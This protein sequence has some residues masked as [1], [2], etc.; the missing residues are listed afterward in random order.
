MILVQYHNVCTRTLFLWCNKHVLWPG[1][2]WSNLT[3]MFIS[4]WSMFQKCHLCIL[5][6]QFGVTPILDSPT[7][8]KDILIFYFF[9]STAHWPFCMVASDLVDWKIA[10]I[11]GQSF[12]L[13]LFGEVWGCHWKHANFFI[14]L[15]LVTRYAWDAVIIAVC[16]HV[17]FV[18]QV[19]R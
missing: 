4:G 6:N 11:E 13:C 16:A 18:F 10:A 9:Y 1:S 14:F 15:L 2:T 5:P 17:F 19:Q 7:K 3:H 12:A 8:D